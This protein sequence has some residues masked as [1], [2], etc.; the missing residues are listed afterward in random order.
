LLY[1]EFDASCQVVANLLDQ[2]VKSTQ[3]EF[4][5]A[6]EAAMSKVT[7]GYTSQIAAQ[8]QQVHS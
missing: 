4:A 6:L 3:Q 8:Q 2:R 7:E 5:D 1:F